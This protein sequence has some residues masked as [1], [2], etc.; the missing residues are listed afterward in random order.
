[1]KPNLVLA[2]FILIMEG[3]ILLMSLKAILTNMGSS[4]KS[5]FH[6]ILSRKNEQATLEYGTFNAILQKC[7]V[8]VLG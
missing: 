4:I 2:L 6:T 7:E 8:D 1:M 3:N 5:L